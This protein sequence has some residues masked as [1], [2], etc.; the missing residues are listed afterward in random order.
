MKTE[1]QQL[2]D[3]GHTASELAAD[4]GISRAAAEAIAQ[5]YH[6]PRWPTFTPEQLAALPEHLRRQVEANNPNH[7]SPAK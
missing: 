7:R 6:A 3:A 2:M 1:A 5:A 4:L